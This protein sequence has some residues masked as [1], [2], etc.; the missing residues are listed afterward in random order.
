MNENKSMTYQNFQNAA[1]AML[2]GQILTLNVYI[3][4]KKIEN[5]TRS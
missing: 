4:K 5:L 3:R 1:T 2:R